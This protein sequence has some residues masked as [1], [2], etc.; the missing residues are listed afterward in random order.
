MDAIDG[1]VSFVVDGEATGE[2]FAELDSAESG[3]EGEEFGDVC[4][5]A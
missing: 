2:C 1:C 4:E 3:G 5:V